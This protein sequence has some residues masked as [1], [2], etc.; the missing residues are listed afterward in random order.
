[1]FPSE[2]Y[3]NSSALWDA[4]VSIDEIA[5]FLRDYRYRDNVGSYVRPGAIDTTRMNRPE[6]AAVFSTD[7]IAGLTRTDLVRAGTGRYGYADPG[8]PAMT[9]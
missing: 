2:V 3:V 6:F 7:F 4:G 9:W 5:A 8:I 1:M